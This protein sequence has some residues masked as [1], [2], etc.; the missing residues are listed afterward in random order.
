MTSF[1]DLILRGRSVLTPL[2]DRGV[3]KE[4]FFVGDPA[5]D[6]ASYRGWFEERGMSA[7]YAQLHSKMGDNALFAVGAMIQALQGSP[8]L[9]E[10]VRAADL[11]THIYVGSALGDLRETCAANASFDRAV[12]VWNRF[13]ASAARCQALR[14][15]RGEGRL[16]PGAAV[17][18]DP[19]LLEPDSEERYEAR[20]AWDAFWAARS[21]ALREFETRYR[22]IEAMPVGAQDD[23]A[24]QSAIRAR[25]RLHRKLQEEFACPLPPW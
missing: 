23:T 7:R 11:G 24:V 6:F 20:A 19:E 10:A 13:W 12:R 14:D 4:L 16:P 18:A 21:E 9:E 15:F 22:E 8:G 3:G 5:F 17:P 25:Q 1:A 2:S